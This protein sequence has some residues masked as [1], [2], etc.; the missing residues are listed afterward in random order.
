[1]VDCVL[2]GHN[3]TD[4]DADRAGVVH[5]VTVGEECPNLPARPVSLTLTIR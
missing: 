4:I 3:F 2:H 5:G 1:M